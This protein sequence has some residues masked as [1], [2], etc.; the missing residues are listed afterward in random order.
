M[1]YSCGSSKLNHGVLSGKIQGTAPSGPQLLPGGLVVGGG[2]GGGGGDVKHKDQNAK[3]S[4]FYVLSN[5]VESQFLEC[6]WV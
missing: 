3:Q 2:V 4:L 6:G 1:V 5:G